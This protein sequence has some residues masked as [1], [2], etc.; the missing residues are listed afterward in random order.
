MPIATSKLNY[1]PS[2]DRLR[3]LAS[4][5]GSPKGRGEAVLLA[6]GFKP[7]LLDGLTRDG[8]AVRTTE[9]IGR[10]QQI[11][12]VRFKITEAGQQALARRRVISRSAP[13]P[14]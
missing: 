13:A 8:L 3:A 10:V 14:V 5:A 6:H 2:A 1:G 11:K 12:V 9:L 7:A 4:L